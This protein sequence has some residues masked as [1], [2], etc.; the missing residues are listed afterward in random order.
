MRQ[1]IGFWIAVAGV[2]STGHSDKADPRLGF[3]TAA[4]DAVREKI[5]SDSPAPTHS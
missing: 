5:A 3:A 1:I 2:V 4:E